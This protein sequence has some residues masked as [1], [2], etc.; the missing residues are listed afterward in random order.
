MNPQWVSTTGS[1]LEN[2]SV[3][4]TTARGQLGLGARVPAYAP[5]NSQESGSG[6]LFLFYSFDILKKIYC[7]IYY[8]LVQNPKDPKVYTVESPS[9]LSTAVHISPLVQPKSP[10]L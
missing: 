7:I 5:H 2:R 8:H 1:W 10:V 3:S 6:L 4:N 9:L